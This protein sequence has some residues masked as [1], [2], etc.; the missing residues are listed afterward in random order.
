MKIQGLIAK[1]SACLLAVAIISGSI[2][3]WC[4]LVFGSGVESSDFKVASVLQRV[5][6]Y[7]GL[8]FV[9]MLSLGLVSNGLRRFM[10][11]LFCWRT[12]KRGL[13]ANA[14]L[15]V[16]VMLFYAEENW[17]GRH[18]WE[19]FKREWEAKGERF[20]FPSFV[21]PPVPDDQNF[22]MTPIVASCY[23]HVLDRT[24]HRIKPENPNVVNPLEM[25]I[26]RHGV[27]YNFNLALGSWQKS[28]F[29]DLKAWQDHYRTT[30]ITNETDVPAEVRER[31]ARRYGVGPPL[32]ATDEFPVAAEPQ[33]PAADV[34][35]ALSKYDSAIEELHQASRLPHSRYPLEYSAT[36]PAAM[37]FPHY[38]SLKA[39]ASVLRLRAIAELNNEQPQSAL[40]DVQLML[41]L[42]DSISGEPLVWSLR[43]RLQI[44]EYAIQPIWEGLARRQWS[45]EQLAALER[46][47]AGLDATSDYGKVLR[48]ELAWQ[49][50]GIEYLRAER[51]AN[52]VDCMC[53]DPIFWPTLAYRLSPSGWFYLN[54]V[55][56]ARCCQAALPSSTEL[57]QGVLSP[58]IARRF[59]EAAG[60]VRSRGWEPGNWLTSFV[61]PSLEREALTCART[62]TSV[63]LAR[64]A[65]ALERFRQAKGSFPE[66]L[67]ALTP[68]FIRNIPR[69]VV[70]GRPLH[71][72]RT[73]RDSF[74]LYSIGWN[75][76]DDGGE[77]DLAKPATL[78][79]P[80]GDWVWNYPAN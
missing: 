59:E 61:L 13:I 50:K 53:G 39:T 57:G 67:D 22:A 27:P 8:A 18:A 36:N 3:A 78:S 63:D 76:Q 56:L 9:T 43:S 14:G 54:K 58:S 69:D 5:A 42:A 40:A 10:R 16:L 68:M 17:R 38:D 2:A 60:L 34:L 73:E 75:E 33:S 47:L 37:V 11:W 51:M 25:D 46:E 31:L 71:Y 48:S 32:P 41:F 7:S 70:S 26:Y 77:P 12:I 49:L 23:N 24:G 30:S 80:A 64:L 72:R 28:Q 66:T 45:E 52:S 4:R 21:P 62:Q 79:K 1:R 65:C 20:E 55:A 19:K 29:T 74:L 44:V 35:L 6:I 15:L